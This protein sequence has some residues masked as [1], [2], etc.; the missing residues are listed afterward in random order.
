MQVHYI[1]SQVHGEMEWGC[2]VVAITVCVYHLY[3]WC[4]GMMLFFSWWSCPTGCPFVMAGLHKPRSR[5]EVPPSSCGTLSWC[6]W[7]VI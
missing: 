3:A 4:T 2:T 7:R 5:F 1:F 6:V